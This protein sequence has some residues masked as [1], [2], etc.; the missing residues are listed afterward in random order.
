MHDG[1]FRVLHIVQI[2]SIELLFITFIL[3][4]VCVERQ[5]IKYTITGSSSNIIIAATSY[6]LGQTM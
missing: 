4:N 2:Y 6:I 5:I 1:Y 3:T